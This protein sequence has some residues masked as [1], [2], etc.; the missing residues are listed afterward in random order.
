VRK[1]LLRLFL[2]TTLLCGFLSSRIGDKMQGLSA[3]DEQK[4]EEQ[5]R[6]SDGWLRQ[7]AEEPQNVADPVLRTVPLSHRVVSSRLTRLLPT[8]GG[9]PTNHSGRW[10]KGNSFNLRLSPFQLSCRHHCWR[11]STGSSPRLYYVIA[12]RRLLC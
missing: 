11:R 8:H 9:K 3:C 4:S 6:Q 2:V 10:S 7:V 1:F 5:I 12:L